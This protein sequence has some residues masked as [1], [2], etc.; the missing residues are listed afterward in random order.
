MFLTVITV[1]FDKIWML[2][3]VIYGNMD[4]FFKLI[5]TIFTI[6]IDEIYSSVE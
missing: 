5:L 6:E 3:V 1:V 4:L 2:D